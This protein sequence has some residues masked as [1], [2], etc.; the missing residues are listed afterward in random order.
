V[1]ALSH[2]RERNKQ[3]FR[4]D[5]FLYGTVSNIDQSSSPA[6]AERLGPS[7]GNAAS[8]HLHGLLA[9]AGL[10]VR[11]VVTT[12]HLKPLRKVPR[13]RRSVAPEG[14]G[15]CVPNGQTGRAQ[16][17]QHQAR[18]SLTAPQCFLRTV[19]A[20]HAPKGESYAS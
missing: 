5:L 17:H 9:A 10:E 8:A 15:R 13:G 4:D 11:I 7:V 16:R 19:N 14:G 3:H 2:A 12:K 6:A 18:R 1:K 20:C